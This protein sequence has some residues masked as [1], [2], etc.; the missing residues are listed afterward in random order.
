VALVILLTLIPVNLIVRERPGQQRP[1]GKA[2]FDKNMFKD[3]PYLLVMSGLGFTF[4][5]VYFGFYYIV[6]FAQQTLHL[7]STQAVNLLIL[8]NASN[9]PG[10]F[11]P[12]LISDTCLGPLNTLIPCTFLTSSILFL[13]LGSSTSTS[14][15]LVAC[16]YGFAAAGIQSLYNATVWTILKPTR[17]EMEEMKA[18]AARAKMMGEGGKEGGGGNGGVGF[19]EGKARMKLAFVFAI[20]GVACL[21]GAPVGGRILEERKGSWVGAQ[22][23]A[24]CTVAVGGCLLVGARIAREG[25]GSGRV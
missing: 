6:S 17:A 5:G 25:W 13:W 4:W 9:L 19:D 11:L 15:H 20:I 16:F 22:V 7:S 23:F 14:I 1:K 21:T 2:S 24:A 10:R 3:T 18:R 12:P 8:M